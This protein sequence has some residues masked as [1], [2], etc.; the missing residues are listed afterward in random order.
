M[1]QAAGT[2][3]E[4][5]CPP[6]QLFPSQPPDWHRAAGW[7]L[8]PLCK[9]G[10]CV[11]AETQI[12]DIEMP[13]N[14]TAALITFFCWQM[15]ADK[16]AFSY[17]CWMSFGEVKQGGESSQ[18][19]IPPCSVHP[20]DSQNNRERR[21]KGQSRDLHLPSPFNLEEL[22]PLLSF[23]HSL[24]ATQTLLCLSSVCSE[25][26]RRTEGSLVHSER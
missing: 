7:M 22:L 12:A 23:L 20:Q 9:T 19:H 8:T 1:D 24:L 17:E 15:K 3:L 18:N 10:V 21:Q 26:F 5:T 16:Q 14:S 11:S 4:A 25:M 6:N 2:Q 13:T